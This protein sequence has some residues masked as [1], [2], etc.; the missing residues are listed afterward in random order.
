MAVALEAACPGLGWKANLLPATRRRTNSR[1]LFAPTAIL[2]A[3]LALLFVGLLVRPVIQDASY[4]GSM[5]KEIERLS[6]V[7]GQVNA[8]RQETAD[9]HSRLTVLRQL[10]L[11]TERDLRILS[12]LSRIVPETAWVSDLE[13]NDGGVRITGEAAEA[14]PM[15][16]VLDQSANLTG[17]AFA[18]S[19]TRIDEGER[20]QI[21]AKRRAAEG[22][23]PAPVVAAAAES[24]EPPA[25]IEPVQPVTAQ[26]AVAE[27]KPQ[28][29]ASP[30]APNEPAAKAAKKEGPRTRRGTG[31]PD[32]GEDR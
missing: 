13:I 17:A 9:L 11:R 5:Q 28:A 18:T 8:A 32:T 6:Q 19:L 1:W 2:L 15:L 10:E 21:V 30:A 29:E 25:R 4:V 16:G 14:A 27:S 24:A 7:V 20:F 22:E 31:G 26:P 23:A 12:E 3:A